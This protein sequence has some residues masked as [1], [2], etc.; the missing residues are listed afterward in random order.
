MNPNDLWSPCLNVPWE[1]SVPHYVLFTVS[2]LQLL[3]LHPLALLTWNVPNWVNWS[4]EVKAAAMIWASWS[5]FCLPFIPQRSECGPSWRMAEYHSIINTF[6][7]AI[8]EE[9][10]LLWRQRVSVLGSWILTLWI[11]RTVTQLGLFNVVIVFDMSHNISSVWEIQI[12][13]SIFFVVLHL[14]YRHA[15]SGWPVLL[16]SLI[17]STS[18]NTHCLDNQR[19]GCIILKWHCH[20]IFLNFN[21]LT[22][23]YSVPV[24]L[25]HYWRK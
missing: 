13:I 15:V 19:C 18:K 24:I 1:I 22:Q 5:K 6:M 25:W 17:R 10:K 12:K 2:L 11:L 20:L 21:M 14:T 7:A 16:W 9:L 3:L 4:R 23:N 8:W